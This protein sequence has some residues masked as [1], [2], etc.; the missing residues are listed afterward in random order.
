MS[1]GSKGNKGGNG[2]G[3][4][5][6]LSP[7]EHAQR[8]QQAKARQRRGH[9]SGRLGVITPDDGLLAG[10]RS[11]R[12]DSWH[13][14]LD[15]V[16]EQAVVLLRRHGNN[17]PHGKQESRWSPETTEMAV[18]LLESYFGDEAIDTILSSQIVRDVRVAFARACLERKVHHLPAQSEEWYTEAQ[19]KAEQLR[20]RRRKAPVTAN[21]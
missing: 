4:S 6:N 3:P 2:G 9:R 12:A 19:T 10:I 11:D 1:K 7:E 14:Y 20:A 17:P 5:K 18:E 15:D 8:K 13:V 21:T 16:R